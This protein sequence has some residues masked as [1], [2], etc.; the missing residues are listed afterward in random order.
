PY[1]ARVPS[2]HGTRD[3]MTQFVNAVVISLVVFFGVL[4]VFGFLDGQSSQAT[5]PPSPGG[6][7]NITAV[8][9]SWVAG[10]TGPQI[11]VELVLHN[12]SR[13]AATATTLT[14]EISVN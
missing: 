8:H 9:P 5:T 4:A 7:L 10:D 3:D 14:A 12:P 13:V 2:R 1:G 6:R 11:G